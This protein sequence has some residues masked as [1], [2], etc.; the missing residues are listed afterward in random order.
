MAYTLTTAMALGFFAVSDINLTTAWASASDWDNSGAA[1]TA[2]GST[3]TVNDNYVMVEGNNATDAETISITAGKTLTVKQGVTLTGPLTLAIGTANAANLQYN[4]DTIKATTISGTGKIKG[5][6]IDKVTT[7]TIKEATLEGVTILDDAAIGNSTT[8][9]TTTILKDCKVNNEKI[10]TIA[11]DADNVLKLDG[12]LTGDGATGATIAG[13]NAGPKLSG[14][15]VVSGKVKLTANINASALTLS[16][17]VTCD[18]T[19]LVLTGVMTA[20]DLTMLGGVYTGS[21]ATVTVKA[22]GDKNDEKKFTVPVKETVEYGVATTSNYDASTTIPLSTANYAVDLSNVSGIDSGIIEALKSKVDNLLKEENAG[23]AGDKCSVGRTGTTTFKPGDYTGADNLNVSWTVAKKDLSNAQINGLSK[24]GLTSAITA[25]SDVASAC[26][27]IIPDGFVSIE[28]K[29]KQASIT[30]GTTTLFNATDFSNN[31]YNASGPT[32]NCTLVYKDINGRLIQESLTTANYELLPTTPVTTAGEHT[33]KVT[34]TSNNANFKGSFT[35]P[36]TIVDYIATNSPNYDGT[37]KTPTL[38]ASVDSTGGYSKD[39]TT[40]TDTAPSYVEAGDYSFKIKE[41]GEVKT[42]MFTIKPAEVAATWNPSSGTYTYD[43][44]VRAPKVTSVANSG[45]PGNILAAFD[46]N[47]IT[48]D[49]YKLGAND[50]KKKVDKCVDA[51]EYEVKAT[52]GTKNKNFKLSA[53]TVEKEFTITKKTA[54]IINGDNVVAFYDGKSHSIEPLKIEAPDNSYV[55]KY[56]L[57][58]GEETSLTAPTFKEEGT[59]KIYYKVEKDADYEANDS[60]V[61]NIDLDG[62]LPSGYITLTIKPALTIEL[63]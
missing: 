61:I 19:A 13:G 62:T 37:A 63:V 38:S 20:K 57:E 58:Q 42:A 36:Y 44:A 27:S 41:N 52:L 16:G 5:A 47:D 7:L 14:S 55:V 15:A 1:V 3:I 8:D 45:I 59:H 40:W 29:A 56:G 26:P 17:T 35:I 49:Y 60:E 31:V 12:T 23:T 30:P 11:N 32:L 25:A 50:T 53:A 43:G 33:L 2:E 18:N 9:G 54:T 28:L 34:A 21:N 10:L 6:K 46:T 48:Y 4:N 39:G 24:L 22:A 51:G